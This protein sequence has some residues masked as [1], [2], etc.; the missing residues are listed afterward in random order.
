MMLYSFYHRSIIFLFFT[1]QFINFTSLFSYL[2]FSNYS[3]IFSSSSLTLIYLFSLSDLFSFQFSLLPHFVV[4]VAGGELF[5][6]L[7]NGPLSERR[8]HNYFRQ[9]LSG[10]LYLHSMGIAHRDLKP[11]NILLEFASDTNYPTQIPSNQ[12]PYPELKI[13]DFG[14]S[15]IVGSG[16][17]KATVCGTLE[18]VAP[19]ILNPVSHSTLKIDMWS[20]G[21]LLFIMLC[22]YPPFSAE[23]QKLQPN[24]PSLIDQI[25]FGTPF[26]DP[27]MWKGISRE[28]ID[29]IT[30]LLQKDPEKRLSAAECT[31]HPWVRYKRGGEKG[32][33]TLF[34]QIETTDGILFN[35]PSQ[36]QSNRLSSSAPQPN[37]PLDAA[38]LHTP[39]PVQRIMRSS[40][41]IPSSGYSP[42]LP[43]S[44]PL[45]GK[46]YLRTPPNIPQL[47]R[48]QLSKRNLSVE[49]PSVG[50][51]QMQSLAQDTA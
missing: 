22:G 41:T 32:N 11:E 18:Y 10:V 28:A 38:E 9:L 5:E 27:Q 44:T 19:E 15:R 45:A 34:N 3:S 20:L 17:F 47:R 26:Y 6:Q 7:Q 30:K 48:A 13:T 4:S 24:Y 40:E 25:R 12:S 39:A 49:T 1:G 50:A 35:I 36:T 42:P 33:I 14:I 31:Q 8:A 37:P 51:K 29:L 23:F 16:T 43:Y 2:S 21:V 46:N